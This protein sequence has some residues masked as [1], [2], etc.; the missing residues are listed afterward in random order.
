LR[1]RT[2]E[3]AVLKAIGF[4]KQRIL[5]LV[6]AEAMLVAG[7]GG[8]LGTVGSKLLCDVV[9]ISRF[10]GGFL[11]FFYIPWSTAL[12]GLAVALAIGFVSGLVPAV[13]AARLSV[14]RG[15]RKVA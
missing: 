11:P 14:V 13:S 8:L 7:L 2:T 3:I 9:D 4:G 15:L 5:F 1:E 12:L 10:S 6:L